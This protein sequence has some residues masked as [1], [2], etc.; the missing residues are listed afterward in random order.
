MGQSR[1]LFVY[2]HHFLIAISIIRI[3]NCIDCVLEIRTRGRMMVGADKH[4]FLH[5]RRTSPIRLRRTIP[6]RS[7]SRSIPRT[8]A[9]RIIRC[10]TRRTT[11]CTRSTRSLPMPRK[12][13]FSS[14][15]WRRTNTST[16]TKPWRTRSSSSTA[17]NTT[18]NWVSGITGY[19]EPSFVDSVNWVDVLCFN[20][21]DSIIERLWILFL[22]SE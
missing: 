2:F 16:W 1:P 18:E 3:E 17:Y 11:T 13:S 15:V 22:S 5:F 20:F 9:T 6:G 8:K 12:T 21:L 4:H 10:P 14:D 19:S 7:S